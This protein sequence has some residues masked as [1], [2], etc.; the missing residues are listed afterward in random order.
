VSNAPMNLK[1]QLLA[2][3]QVQELDLKIDQLKSQKK[4]LPL[5]L[6][7]LDDSAR[8]LTQAAEIKKAV[9]SEMEKAHRQSSAAQELNQDRIQRAESKIAAS[10]TSPRDLQAAQR[11]MDQLKK[12]SETLNTQKAKTQLDLESAKKAYDSTEGEIQKIKDQRAAQE[13]EIAAREKQIDASLSELMSHRKGAIGGIGAPLLTWYDRVRGARAG[14]G[15]APAV[16]GSCRGCNRM[17]PPQMYNELQKFKEQISCP[18]CHRI[19]YV[20]SAPTS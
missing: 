2:L 11:E 14:I 7:S 6:K 19:L 3:V 4:A 20:P 8:K 10:V 18:T 12:V 16:A 17:V 5:E 15:I 1:E 13:A 9:M